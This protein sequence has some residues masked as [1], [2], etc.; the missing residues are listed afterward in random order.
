MNEHAA[1][2]AWADRPA[3][4]RLLDVPGDVCD[5]LGDVERLLD[6]GGDACRDAVDGPAHSNARGTGL[7]L[8]AHL[9]L[10]RDD[11]SAKEP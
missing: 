8:S 5:C 11:A 2:D 4:R 1:E 9:G 6:C 7:E 3:V 10:P